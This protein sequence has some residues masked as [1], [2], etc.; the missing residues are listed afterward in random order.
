MGRGTACRAPT[1][2]RVEA[3]GRPVVGSLA[4][5]VRSF[6]SA[7][8]KWIND[9]R[10]GP[11]LPVWQR[12]YYEHVVREEDELARIRQYIA[13]NH[14]RGISIEKIPRPPRFDQ[15]LRAN[16][17]GTACRAPTHLSII[18]PRQVGRGRF[19]GRRR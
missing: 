18:T 5:I 8:T 16:R 15:R 1:A 6:K 19:P 11:R 12:S 3:F 7:V 4:T 10:H 17:R 9:R 14:V 2:D 13:D